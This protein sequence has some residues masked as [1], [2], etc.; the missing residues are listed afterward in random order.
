MDTETALAAFAALS[1]ETRL[2]AFRLLMAEGPSGLP[3]GEIAERL[4]VPQS[5]LSFHLGQ[6]ERAGLVT[7]TRRAR[8]ILYAADFEGT[9]RLLGFLTED[10]CRG[11]PEVCGTAVAALAEKE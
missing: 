7:A 6:L 1:Q 10:C 11:R 9:R 2:A 3:A 8:H 4:G 5:T